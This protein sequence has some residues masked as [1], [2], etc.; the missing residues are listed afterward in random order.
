MHTSQ[1]I[2]ELIAQE[3][4]QAISRATVDRALETG[5][6]AKEI[7]ELSDQYKDSLT[8]NGATNSAN[9]KGS[10]RLR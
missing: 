1:V 3:T 5:Q 2:P 6:R 7:A 9:S 4:G 8:K 10:F